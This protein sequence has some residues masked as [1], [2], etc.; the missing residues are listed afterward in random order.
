LLARDPGS[1][2][3][4]DDSEG[5][6]SPKAITDSNVNHPAGSTTCAAAGRSAAWSS[7]SLACTRGDVNPSPPPPPPPAPTGPVLLR[8]GR[9]DRIL[10]S[11]T[12]VT[13][14]SAFDG[15]ILVEDDTITCVAASCSGDPGAADASVAGLR[16]PGHL[17]AEQVP[18]R[19]GSLGHRGKQLR[20]T[21]VS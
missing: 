1:C 15:E 19:G 20:P 3:Y 5:G 7:A 16:G 4:A 17:R 6:G 21:S 10:L 2:W 11:G 12:L 18:L 8:L 13:P 14:D 9:P